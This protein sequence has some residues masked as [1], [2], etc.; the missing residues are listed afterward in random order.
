MLADKSSMCL[1]LTVHIKDK[2]V[3]ICSYGDDRKNNLVYMYY[4]VVHQLISRL[5]GTLVELLVRES[6]QRN[7]GGRIVLNPLKG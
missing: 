2:I 6:C 4:I 7:Y 5:G 1:Y 3:G